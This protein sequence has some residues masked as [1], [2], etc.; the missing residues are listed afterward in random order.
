MRIKAEDT[1]AL[2]VDCQESLMK[3]MYQ[4]EELERSVQILIRGLKALG[5]PMILTQQYTKGLGNSVPSVYEAAETKEYM[6]KIS[7]SCYQDSEIAAAVD[8]SGRKNILICGIETHICVLQTCIDLKTAGYQPVLVADCVSSRRKS[9]RDIGL[10]R[11]V[12][13]G[14]L[15]TSYEAILFELLEKA[16]GDTF[17]TISKLIK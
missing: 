9:D 7:F 13:E 14:V 6:D 3:V 10:K 15:L 4:A 11:A 8:G 2:I 12:Q 17:K 5:I 16:G 1:M